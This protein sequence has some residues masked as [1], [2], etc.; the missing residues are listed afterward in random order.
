[1][2]LTIKF[3][4]LLSASIVLCIPLHAMDLPFARFFKEKS[5][6]RSVQKSPK[7]SIEAEQKK[8]TI[9]KNACHAAS[10]GHIY[11]LEEIVAHDYSILWTPI[12]KGVTPLSL[13]CY[14]GHNEMAQWILQKTEN[15]FQ[16]LILKK[17]DGSSQESTPLHLA[18]HKGHAQIIQILLDAWKNI[19]DIVN[20]HSYKDRTPLHYAV[21][22]NHFDAVGVLLQNGA[23]IFEHE[24]SGETPLTLAVKLK[25]RLIL[26]EFQKAFSVIEFAKRSDDDLARLDQLLAAKFDLEQ[27]DSKYHATALI[28]AANN[29]HSNIVY[30][31][32]KAGA[33]V[34]A[35]NKD[36][37][38][39]FDCAT[40]QVNDPRKLESFSEYKKKS[41]RTIQRMLMAAMSEKQPASDLKIGEIII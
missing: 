23:S 8:Q 11:E 9:I 1:M 33:N 17:E 30:A 22:N 35:K 19:A 10:A 26:Q 20:F 3:T 24:E 13:A 25:N 18:A 14:Y 29:G 36:G 4:Q 7:R 6:D 34:H 16:A 32:L 39:A 40:Q 5:K 12:A 28:W 37:L 15:R 41:Y 38:T 2:K 31:L 21:A 27:V